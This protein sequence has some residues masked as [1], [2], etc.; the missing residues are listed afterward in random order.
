M[1]VQG[2]HRFEYITMA[3]PLALTS[4][5]GE[6]LT[7]WLAED[8]LVYLR[9]NLTHQLFLLEESGTFGGSVVWAMRSS[10]G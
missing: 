7:V 8:C 10:A 9:G 3:S 6:G 4:M 1:P 2:S 5:C